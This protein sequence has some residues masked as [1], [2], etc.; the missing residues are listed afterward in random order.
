M[1]IVF[2]IDTEHHV[3][4]ARATGVLNDA[5]MFDYQRTVWSRPEVAGFD[6][7]VDMTEAG[8]V[9]MGTGDRMIRLAAASAETDIPGHPAKLA[10]IASEPLHFGLARMYQTYRELDPRSTK[11]VAVFRTRQEALEWLGLPVGKA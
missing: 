10:I 7:I 2:S 3:V 6:E 8:Q 9:E 1:P 11:K 5:D 4:W